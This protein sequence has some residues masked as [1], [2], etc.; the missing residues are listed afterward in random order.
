MKFI[1]LLLA[2]AAVGLALA[3]TSF[4]ECAGHAKTATIQPPATP[5]VSTTKAG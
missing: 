4:A 2:T 3:S 1:T 5:V